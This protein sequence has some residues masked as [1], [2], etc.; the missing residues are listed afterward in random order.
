MPTC[1]RTLGPS[2]GPSRACIGSAC[3]MWVPEIECPNG[4]AFLRQEEGDERPPTGRGVCADNL[5]A[6]PFAD[7]AKGE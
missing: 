4:D 2:L 6:V 5:R 7:P 1:H 3:V